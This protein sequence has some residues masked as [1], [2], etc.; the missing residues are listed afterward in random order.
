M[1]L[2][3]LENNTSIALHFLAVQ[4]FVNG[5]IRVFKWDSG[6]YTIFDFRRFD[7]LSLTN[8]ESLLT[9]STRQHGFHQIAD[10]LLNEYISI[11]CP[12]MSPL[13]L[14]LN[15]FKA[16]YSLQ[17]LRKLNHSLFQTD[18]VS[19]YL[20]HE[21]YYRILVPSLFLI[22]YGIQKLR[23][24]HNKVEKKEESQQQSTSMMPFFIIWFGGIY[25]L[26]D[27]WKKD[28]GM[29]ENVISTIAKI[30]K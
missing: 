13:L 28:V 23:I 17:N 12:S 19:L 16:I 30:L 22:V 1:I 26:N 20:L 25:Y 14:V 21:I 7:L 3:Y 4:S 5:I 10:F 27:L 6:M 18:R 15:L 9:V 11:K 24:P 2:K 29:F 8:T